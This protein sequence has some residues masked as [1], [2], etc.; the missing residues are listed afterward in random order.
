MISM[1]ADGKVFLQLP[2]AMNYVHKFGIT[3]RVQSSNVLLNSPLVHGLPNKMIKPRGRRENTLR[4]QYHRFTVVGASVYPG[5][6]RDIPIN[7]DSP[8]FLGVIG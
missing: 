1:I 5:W 3:G 2:D 8:Y 7:S 6:M 4:G